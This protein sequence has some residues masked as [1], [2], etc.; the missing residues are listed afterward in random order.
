MIFIDEC[1]IDRNSNEN[2]PLE[3]DLEL[4]NGKIKKLQAN[5][6]EDKLL[7]CNTIE[8]YKK[9]ES[10]EDN[11]EEE[12]ILLSTLKQ[13]I[14]KLEN[15]MDDYYKPIQLSIK[16]SR[17]IN[18]NISKIEEEEEEEEE[19]IDILNPLK[20]LKIMENNIKKLNI[21]TSDITKNMKI[22]KKNNRERKY[23]YKIKTAFQNFQS[24]KNNQNEI[25]NQV[26]H[27]KLNFQNDLKKFYY[28]FD[29]NNTYYDNIEKNFKEEVKIKNIEY[30]ELMEKFN[31]L[32]I[33]NDTIKKEIKENNILKKSLIDD[34]KHFKEKKNK[35]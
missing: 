4:K 16:L 23:D 3:F 22:L 28:F 30:E 34:A 20:S 6:E 18:K 15:L 32:K 25:K 35:K 26:V 10:N 27:F 17:K 8:S 21:Q 7:W 24:I 19:D 13:D 12:E 14:E 29:P 9:Q 33:E 11:E 1:K 5:S 2:D 31:I